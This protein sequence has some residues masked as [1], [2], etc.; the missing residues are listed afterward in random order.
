MSLARQIE[1]NPNNW[2]T[3]IIWFWY[4]PN[5]ISNGPN[6][7][8]L[9]WCR[10]KWLIS[11][12]TRPSKWAWVT[13]WSGCSTKKKL[14]LFNWMYI[15]DLAWNVWEYVNGANTIDWTGND[16]M[17][18]NVCWEWW[19]NDWNTYSFN[20]WIWDD[21]IQCE[22]TNG[23]YSANLWSIFSN[24]NA[25]NGIW[26]ISSYNVDNNIID[27]FFIRGGRARSGASS[28]VFALALNPPAYYK[29]GFRC[30][31]MK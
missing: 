1:F 28:G 11:D 23:Y 17:N 14:E 2:S 21:S 4:I 16:T 18:A 8:N 31:Y 9:A 27:R 12:W 13:W 15:Y 7:I 6:Q 25:I 19:V 26:K 22:Y 5:W 29:I 10:G 20:T 24:L 30:A 3:W